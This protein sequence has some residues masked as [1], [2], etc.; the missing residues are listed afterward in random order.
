MVDWLNMP[1]GIIG[2]FNSSATY[3]VELLLLTRLT[4]VSC[5][6]FGISPITA[7]HHRNRT[8][9]LNIHH[10]DCNGLHRASFATDEIF[11]K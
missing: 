10:N 8:V 1:P 5:R 4:Y 7:I 3:L 6:H 2:G 9:L 11:M